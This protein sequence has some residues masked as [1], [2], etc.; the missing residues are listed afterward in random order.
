M[1]HIQLAKKKQKEHFSTF[2]RCLALNGPKGLLFK[3]KEFIS[4]FQVFITD[5]NF[6]NFLF[7]LCGLSKSFNE[8]SV[9]K[10]KTEKSRN[11]HH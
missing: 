3:I 9:Q 5:R 1:V 11:L 7:A 4:D 6:I 2:V 8:H 10:T